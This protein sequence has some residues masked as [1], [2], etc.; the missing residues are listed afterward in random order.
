MKKICTKEMVIILIITVVFTMWLYG[1]AT[2]YFPEPIH[3]GL[4]QYIDIGTGVI[5]IALFMFGIII[6][7]KFGKKRR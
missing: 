5:I 4:G 7:M 3:L 2:V 6:S 1:M